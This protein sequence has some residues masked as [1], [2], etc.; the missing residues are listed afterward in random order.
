[1]LNE[2][3]VAAKARTSTKQRIAEAAFATLREEGYAGASA[4][5]IAG[6]GKF[7][8]ALIFY[9]FG[10]V[11]E[12]LLAALDWGSEKRLARYRQT[13][14][15]ALTF[16]Q[17]APAAWTLF[18]ED[19][20]SGFVKVLGELIAAG[21]SNPDLGRQ[22]ASR[23][24]PSLAF[25]RETFQRLLGSS[26]LSMFVSVD[27]AAFALTSLYLGLELMCNLER[28]TERAESLFATAGRLA[29]VFGSMLGTGASAPV[30]HQAPVTKMARSRRA[31]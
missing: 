2:V 3:V 21:S 18:K 13:F 17:M 10:G 12:A 28:S 16:D 15:E 9:H 24:E 8:Q 23:V 7:N 25:T 31:K 20:D 6:R 5:A 1:V 11:D 19:L 27:D 22:V 29:T 4:R 26:P 14:G 30:N